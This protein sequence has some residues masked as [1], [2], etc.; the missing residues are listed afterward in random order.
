MYEKPVA[1]ERIVIVGGGA[2]GFFAAI[3][4][5]QANPENDV[6]IFERG[7]EF[8]TKV[9]IS[10]GGR[11][12]V[13]HA[14]FDPR[15][16]ST[17]YPRGERALISPLHRFSASDT[18]AWFEARGVRLKIEPDGRMFPTTDSS[19]TI[20]DCLVKEARNAGVRLFT[21]K[22]IERARVNSS[23]GFELDLSNDQI[24]CD[25]FLLAT[26][27]CRTPAGA[28]VAQSL[29]HSIAPPVPSLFSFHISAQWLRSLP[30]VSLTNAEV[31][32]Q[33]TRLRERGPLLITHNGMSGPVILR[34][35]A[36]GARIF[37]GMNYRFAIRVKWLPDLSEEEI[38]AKFQ[39]LRQSH[40]NR[41]VMNSPIDSLPARL[42][43]QLTI[44][45]GIDRDTRWTTLA[46]TAANAL[47]RL[48]IRTELEV[49]GKSLNKEEF[50]TCGGVS[51]REI[52]FKTMESRIT[53]RLY[54]AGELLDVDGITGGF[55]FQSA[56]TTGW[57]AGRAMAGVEENSVS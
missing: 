36:W 33:N 56:W 54:F 52:N 38:R 24:R 17:H 22:G 19:R 41:R 25:R 30:G 9:R 1:R 13:T 21:R 2:A 8:L 26:G 46:A 3:T 57:I 12:N 6:S 50:V 11:C 31:S 45:A 7:S 28:L 15:A 20:I 16:F 29:G 37:H 40:P 51:L 55:N 23:G 49:N 47:A 27:G 53:P 4:C 42:W 35:S 14:C 10:G 43:E 18:V 5:A 44:A 48:L 32:V 34:L 39:S